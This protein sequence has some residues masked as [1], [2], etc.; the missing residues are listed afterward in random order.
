MSKQVEAVKTKLNIRE[1]AI[2]AKLPILSSSV[3]LV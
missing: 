3:M 2:E 1:I